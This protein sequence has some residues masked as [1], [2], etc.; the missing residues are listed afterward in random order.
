PG[1][2]LRGGTPWLLRQCQ[3]RLDTEGRLKAFLAGKGAPADAA[4]P[5]RLGDLAQQPYKRLYLTAARLYRDGF[6]R[7]PRLAK[8]HRYNAACA[9]ALA[10]CGQAE[11]AGW[12]NAMERLRWRQALTWLRAD[13]R[14][15]QHALQRDPAGNQATVETTMQ[16]WL[17][18]AGF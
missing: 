12:L 8:S 17:H 1:H 7:Q 3:Q 2:P 9:A 4:T 6:A 14:A 13:L 10:G 15:W 16:C 11:D 18:F 5:L